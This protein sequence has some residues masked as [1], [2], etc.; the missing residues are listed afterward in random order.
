MSGARLIRLLAVTVTALAIGVT[1]A[2]ASTRAR[3]VRRDAADAPNGGV[4]LDGWGGLHPTGLPG[5]TPAITGAPYWPGWDI[6]RGIT[7]RAD[8]S[9]G[10]VVDAWG[11]LHWFSVGTP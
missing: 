2:G 7:M 11:G 8:H 6:A 10:F 9:G 5:V 1:P 4:L 3:T